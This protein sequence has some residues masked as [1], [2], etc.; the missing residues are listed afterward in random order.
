M[1]CTREPPQNKRFTQAESEGMEKT[2]ILHANEEKK[3]TGVAILISDR[4]DFK[5][6]AIT[7]DKEGHYIILKGS[8]Q[9]ED[10]ALVNIYVPNTGASKYMK[11]NL[12]GL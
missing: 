12:R 7:T 3:K 10:I 9:Q 4:I 8:I 1:L 5:T 6:K 11:K 2:K